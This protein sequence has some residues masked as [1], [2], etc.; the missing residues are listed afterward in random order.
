VWRLLW[1]R[2]P[3]RPEKLPRERY[4]SGH[5]KACGLPG[6]PQGTNKTF[7]LWLHNVTFWSK[8][9]LEH[10]ATAEGKGTDCDSHLLWNKRWPLWS[11][12]AVVKKIKRSQ[13]CGGSA[14]RCLAQ[15]AKQDEQN[16]Q[17]A[18]EIRLLNRSSNGSGGN[19]PP[20]RRVCLPRLIGALPLN[21]TE[22]R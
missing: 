1:Q 18:P 14:R 3:E 15:G 5:G 11:Q 6:H 7:R 10:A 12:H 22:R 21:W 20:G 17:P 2:P 16:P 9:C 4:L 13:L 19:P 8:Q